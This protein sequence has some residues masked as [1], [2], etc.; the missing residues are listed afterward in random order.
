MNAKARWNRSHFTWLAA[1]LLLAGCTS[2]YRIDKRIPISESVD[3]GRYVVVTIDHEKI[4]GRKLVITADSV[5]IDRTA[6]DKRDVVR[7]LKR[8]SE[9]TK[10][11]L[12]VWGCILGAIAA[13]SLLLWDISQ[14]NK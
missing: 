1:L 8:V 9:P 14:I 4:P 11:K 6:L 10:T 5:F 2:G 12:M 7:I 3:H 13:V